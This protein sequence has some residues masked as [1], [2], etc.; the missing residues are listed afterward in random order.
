MLATVLRE[1]D[2]SYMPDKFKIQGI[3]SLAE[4]HPYLV[5]FVGIPASILLMASGVTLLT[6]DLEQP[7]PPFIGPEADV[8]PCTYSEVHDM[9]AEDW[10]VGEQLIGELNDYRQQNDIQLLRRD[11]VL[12]EEA[13]YIL[14][15]LTALGSNPT[16]SDHDQL[17]GVALY[18]ITN[19]QGHTE[20]YRSINQA[21]A[22][23]D[24]TQGIAQIPAYDMLFAWEEEALGRLLDG[25]ADSIGVAFQ[26]LGDYSVVV[27]VTA[28]NTI[29]I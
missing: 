28:D 1:Y 4:K 20:A 5:R 12:T 10:L 2:N 25:P 11:Q 17:D 23:F 13:N 3:D 22:S 15:A 29:A 6:S 7:N 24:R 18:G 16:R 21:T 19:Y 26:N 8:I 9:C 27:V 14:E